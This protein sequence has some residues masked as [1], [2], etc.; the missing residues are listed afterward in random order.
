MTI[1]QFPNRRTA[2]ALPFERLPLGALVDV[3]LNIGMLDVWLPGTIKGR[4]QMG[5]QL[6]HVELGIDGME[7][8]KVPEARI[9]LCESHPIEEK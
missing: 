6:Y 5:K 4:S 3:R 9:R 7:M 2:A 1:A 8:V